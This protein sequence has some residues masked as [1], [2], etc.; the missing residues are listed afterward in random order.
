MRRAM[1]TRFGDGSRPA[2]WCLGRRER[3]SG[4]MR[5]CPSPCLPPDLPVPSSPALQV[6]SIIGQVRPDRQTLLFSATMPRKVGL[7]SI[8]V[9]GNDCAYGIP[10][11]VRARFVMQVGPGLHPSSVQRL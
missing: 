7:L 9:E 3:L 1:R 2:G 10:G 4:C 8:Y 5:N 6:R 11:Q